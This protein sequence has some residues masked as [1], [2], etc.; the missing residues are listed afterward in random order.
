[1]L[2]STASLVSF[3]TWPHFQNLSNR[4]AVLVLTLGYVHSWK[5]KKKKER[6]KKKKKFK[7][8]NEYGVYTWT[9]RRTPPLVNK[10]Y[11]VAATTMPPARNKNM[12]R[13]E[14]KS[15]RHRPHF[16]LRLLIFKGL[17]WKSKFVRSDPPNQ[18]RMFLQFISVRCIIGVKPRSLPNTLLPVRLINGSFRRTAAKSETRSRSVPLMKICRWNTADL[19]IT[20]SQLCWDLRAKKKKILILNPFWSE[21][22]FACF[23]Y[24]KEFCSESYFPS[25]HDFIII[26]NLP[27]K[28]SNVCRE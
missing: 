5:K 3:L 24:R 16:L 11:N 18:H 2:A 4:C 14:S 25:L 27:E 22:S 20:P 17:Q 15:A 1:M 28:Y 6:E 12:W 26:L 21:C 19:E 23:D 10:N 7:I 13:N 9:G 8:K